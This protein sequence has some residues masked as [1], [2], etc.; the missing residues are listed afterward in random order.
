M[1]KNLKIVLFIILGIMI[2]NLL[3]SLFG[4]N[5]NLRHTLEK[6]NDA[7]RKLDKAIEQINDSEMRIDSMQSDL[8]KFGSYLKDVQG[9]VELLD[10]EKRLNDRRYRNR[11]DSLQARL[12]ELYQTVDTTGADL[13]DITIDDSR[14]K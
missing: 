2:A 9:R 14:P 4:A 12:K 5:R 6:L 3:V 7:E 13:P 1:D 11:R 8:V 10:L